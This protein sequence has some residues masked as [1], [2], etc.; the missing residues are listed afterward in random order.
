M[1]DWVIINVKSHINFIAKNQKKKEYN[2]Q[3]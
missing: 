1:S 2:Y 3:N